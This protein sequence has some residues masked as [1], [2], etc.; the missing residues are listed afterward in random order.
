MTVG[1]N[2]YKPKA[3]RSMSVSAMVISLDAEMTSYTS[4]SKIQ[5]DQ[6]VSQKFNEAFRSESLFF[7]TIEKGVSKFK[8]NVYYSFSVHVI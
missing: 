1:F 4:L 8:L 2:L 6:F 7:L 5:G 3:S